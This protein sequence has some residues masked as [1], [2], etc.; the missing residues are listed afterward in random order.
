[1]QLSLVC[2]LTSSSAQDLRLFIAVTVCD[3]SPIV[4]H[5]CAAVCALK[6]HRLYRPE[7]GGDPEPPPP[8][9]MLLSEPAHKQK[10]YQYQRCRLTLVRYGLS[11]IQ[12]HRG[13]GAFC[14]RA[15][16]L[17]PLKLAEHWSPSI[18]SARKAQQQRH[19]N[20][21]KRLMAA[22]S[23]YPIHISGHQGVYT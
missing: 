20:V 10:H 12:D 9:F 19:A 8:K 22:L 11:N 2:C 6:L 7:G 15:H 1:M 4:V 5:S 18:T 21:G 14:A 16:A 17:K 3:T 13:I 23:L